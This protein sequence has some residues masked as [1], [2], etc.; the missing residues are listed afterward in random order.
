M[1]GVLVMG[2][3]SDGVTQVP[4]AC[5]SEGLPGIYSPAPC[6]PLYLNYSSAA[7]NYMAA[8]TALTAPS[9]LLVITGINAGSKER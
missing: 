6:I 8:L 2:A 7:L 1:T 9:W 3:N 5:E 4:S